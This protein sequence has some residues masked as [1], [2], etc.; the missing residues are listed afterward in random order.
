M[1]LTRDDLF[2]AV[3][4]LTAPEKW[5]YHRVPEICKRGCFMYRFVKRSFVA[6]VILVALVLVLG[7]CVS[8]PL[9]SR[10]FSHNRLYWDKNM[11]VDQSVELCLMQGLT[12]TS[13][14]GI[15]VNWGFKP[16]IFLPTGQT[17]LAL[18]LNYWLGQTNVKGDAVFVWNFKAGDR[19]ILH[20]WRRDGK[21][22][23][24]LWNMDVKKELAE[25]DF[26]PFPESK[27]ILE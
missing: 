6:A 20:G 18:D 2:R 11:P 10:S 9:N 21:L 25:Y 24:L 4:N 19:F 14:N 3:Q 13:Y 7:S 16:N 5:V 15:P 8:Y 17:A 23:I 12:A 1:E 27:M 22:G 26:F